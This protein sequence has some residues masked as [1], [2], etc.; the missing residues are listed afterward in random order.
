[1]KIPVQ[2]RALVLLYKQQILGELL[3]QE[4]SATNAS[5]AEHARTPVPFRRFPKEAASTK[6]TR[7]P[8]SIAAR[9]KTDAPSAQ[10][11]KSNLWFAQLHTKHPFIKINRKYTEA[12]RRVG[13]SVFKKVK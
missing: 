13:V 3:W 11:P 4:L 8:A 6:S 7:E 10:F 2:N 5:A 9:A 12:P 1:L